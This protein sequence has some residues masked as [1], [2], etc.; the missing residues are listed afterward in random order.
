MRIQKDGKEIN[1]PN[2]ILFVGIL[3]VDNITT[4]V[5]RVINNKNHTKS[6][7]KEEREGL[8]NGSL[9]LYALQNAAGLRT[10]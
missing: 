6:M 10:V 2:W 3:A 9:F 4:N 8:S 1:V 7:E 5:L